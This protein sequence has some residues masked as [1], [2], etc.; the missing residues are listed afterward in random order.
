MSYLISKQGFL[1]KLVERCKLK[2]FGP[3]TIKSY[4]FHVSAFLDYLD[5]SRLNL[6]KK[7]VK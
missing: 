7:D 1:D 2:G 5:K 4:K 6:N 3:Q